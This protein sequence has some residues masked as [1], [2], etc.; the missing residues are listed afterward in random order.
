VGGAASNLAKSDA[1]SLKS[2]Q[3]WESISNETAGDRDVEAGSPAPHRNLDAFVDFGADVVGN[4]VVFVTEQ[5]DGRCS[6]WC[7]TRQCCRTL[8][9][10]NGDDKLSG[11]ALRI[12]PALLG[13][14]D[15]VDAGPPT[16][17]GVADT[18]RILVVPRGRYGQTC[19][20]LRRRSGAVCRGWRR[21]R[22]R[23]GRR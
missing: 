1:L 23:A 2:G 5:Q 17:Q 14:C 11:R 10:L 13:G 6:R 21:R 7:K 22:P 18:E 16:A 15:P 12:D 8:G 3:P 4:A 19:T 9:E 20:D